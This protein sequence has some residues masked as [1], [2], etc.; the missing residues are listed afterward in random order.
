MACPA[1]IVRKVP[2]STF[3]AVPPVSFESHTRMRGKT[4]NSAPSWSLDE[5]TPAC[6]PPGKSLRTSDRTFWIV[7]SCLLV[8]LNP[9]P[10]KLLADPSN[11][12]PS[13]HAQAVFP[14]IQREN[15]RSLHE[16][17]QI[18]LGR[19]SM[20]PKPEAFVPRLVFVQTLRRMKPR[21]HPRRCGCRSF[22]PWPVWTRDAIAKTTF[23]PVA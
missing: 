23:G 2:D 4:S 7:K 10:T 16:L 11:R 21:N 17:P 9:A 19:I 14:P 20:S 8:V 12:R 18:G 6:K 13:V 5:Y 1:V 3:P 15:R 22:W